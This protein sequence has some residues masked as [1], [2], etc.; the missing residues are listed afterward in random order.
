MKKFIKSITTLEQRRKIRAVMDGMSQGMEKA[1]AGCVNILPCSMKV[2]LKSHLKVVKKMD[3]EKSVIV[4]DV[5]SSMEQN[6][7]LNSC[8]KEPETVHWI[9]SFFKSGEVFFDVGANVGAYSLVAAKCFKGALKVYSFEPSFLNF[10]QLCHNIYLNGCGETIVPFNVA[11]SSK[12][13]VDWFNYRSLTVGGAMHALGEPKDD[14]DQVFTP[15]F[16]QPM[17]G[18]TMDDFIVHFSLPVPHHIKIDVDGI[19]YQILQGAV[20]TLNDSRVQSILLE[21]VDGETQITGF[22]QDKGF[23][24]HERYPQPGSP[25]ANCI[26]KRTAA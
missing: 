6:V 11:F 18:F 17:L 24:L 25:L 8:H 21:L 1:A 26:F 20:K 12:T 9:E 10:G 23:V 3:Y 22:L 19:E 14:F 7:R 5:S 4:L 13:A 16:K 15:V 2:F